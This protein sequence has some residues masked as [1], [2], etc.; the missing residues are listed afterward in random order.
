MKATIKVASAKTPATAAIIAGFATA[1]I[2]SNLALIACNLVSIL[3]SIP[4]SILSATELRLA[5]KVPGFR[6][7]ES[8]PW[9]DEGTVAIVSFLLCP[10]RS[11]ASVSFVSTGSTT[12]H[13]N[14]IQKQIGIDT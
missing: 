2:S 1:A 14:N 9:S 7:I 4:P 8:K 10:E 13:I 5:V 3:S 6:I 12:K 11:C